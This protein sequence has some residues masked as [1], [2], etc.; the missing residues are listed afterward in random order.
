MR[1]L[2][3]GLRFCFNAG[4]R[5]SRGAGVRAWDHGLGFQFRFRV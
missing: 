3:G 2:V 1:V 4:L 5:R